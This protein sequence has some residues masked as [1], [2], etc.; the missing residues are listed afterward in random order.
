MTDIALLYL[1]GAEG[2]LRTCLKSTPDL[3]KKTDTQVAE[4]TKENRASPSAEFGE[5][6]AVCVGSSLIHCSAN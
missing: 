1:H 5:G 3:G 4:I 6:P 2:K